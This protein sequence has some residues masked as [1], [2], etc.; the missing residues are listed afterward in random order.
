LRSEQLN[1]VGEARLDAKLSQMTTGVA[2]RLLKVVDP[3]FRKNGA[4]VIPIK[5]EGTR[6]QPHV[7]LNF[8]FGR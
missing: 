5:I 4:T 2:S 7:S 1:F 3:F 8:K 6:A